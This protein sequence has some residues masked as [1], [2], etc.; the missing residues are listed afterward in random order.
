VAE[1][2]V[3]P[4]RPASVAELRALQGTELGPTEWY[5]VTQ[6]RIDAFARATEDFQWIHVDPERTAASPLGSTIAHGL[7]TL[8]L[9]PRFM[10][11]LLAFDGF[12]H[13][14]NVGYG[15]VRFPAPVPVGSRLRMRATIADVRELDGAAQVT[16]TQ[17]FEI[18]GGAKPVCVAE[19]LGRFFERGAGGG[20]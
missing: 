15:R 3:S 10:E 18:D 5:D 13:A 17:A 2:S 19:S 20:A 14:L 1:Q 16:T 4:V 11:E 9:G 6:G 7:F 8:S 12:A